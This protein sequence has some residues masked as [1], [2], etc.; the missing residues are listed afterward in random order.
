LREPGKIVYKG[1]TVS[2][3]F[4]LG[5][6]ITRGTFLNTLTGTHG[7][8]VAFSFNAGL[9]VSVGRVTGQS[10]SLAAF[11]GGNDNSFGGA[12]ES[13]SSFGLGA[14]AT[15]SYDLDGNPVGSSTTVGVGTPAVGT[16]F[17]NTEITS[18]TQTNTCARQ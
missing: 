17:S 6:S 15:T 3:T 5:A 2:A 12:G 4:L 13:T 11:S 7:T 9:D 14:T 1:Y 16:S 8:F 10:N 18:V